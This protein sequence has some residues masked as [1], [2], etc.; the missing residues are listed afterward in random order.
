MSLNVCV[1]GRF[2]TRRMTGVDRFAIE[3]LTAI[4]NLIAA[5]DPCTR[6]LDIEVLVPPG[7][8]PTRQFQA[9]PVKLAG[10]RQGT[11]WEQL[12]LP[13]LVPKGSLLLNLCNTGPAFKREQVV[14]I[15]DAGT[16]R[17]PTGFSRGFRW[18]YKVLMP[19]LGVRAKRILTV[20]KFSQAELSD[21][22]HI[23][24]T[25]IAVLPE[26][27][28]H[29][30]RVPLEPDCLQRFQLGQ[31]PYL[32]AVSSMAAHKN[33]QLVLD[34]LDQIDEPPFDVAIAGGANARIFGIAG[35]ARSDRVRWLGYVSDSELRTLYS[36]AIGFVFPSLY[37]GFGIPPLEA[38]ACGCPVLAARAASMPEV[39]GD[40]AL[41]FDPRDAAGLA[42][43]MLRI[44]ADG[45]L[46]A[47]L[48][49]RG[50]RRLVQYSWEMAARRLLD[51]CRIAAF[52]F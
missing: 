24:P 15:H 52:K 14:V 50:Q 21:V 37:E 51:E 9:I 32:L 13:R 42:E 43:A 45:D 39:L 29:I 33:F 49:A 19:L 48:V 8:A 16:E 11:Q 38:M 22:Y 18:W 47:E 41:Y 6:D 27:A 25:K 26:G 5:G 30:L 1:N 34:A 40:A 7:N 12:E 35:A 31:R 36:S 3:V 17:M 46:R 23:S 28:E 10:R 2:L 44:A 20:S 4:D